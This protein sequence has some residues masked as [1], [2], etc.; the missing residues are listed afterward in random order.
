MIRITLRRKGTK[1]SMKCEG[2]VPEVSF[3]DT[4]RIWES[5]AHYFPV[6]YYGG[7][8]WFGLQRNGEVYHFFETISKAKESIQKTQAAAEEMIKLIG[9]TPRVR[10]MI[11]NKE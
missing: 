3:E 5:G 1:V 2:D 8:I 11:N 6:V 10:G 4:L 7:T 9:K